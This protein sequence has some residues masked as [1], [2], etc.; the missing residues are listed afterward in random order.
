MVSQTLVINNPT[1]LHTRPG[2]RFVKTAQQ[3]ESDITVT[4]GE[5]SANGKSLLKMLKL[6]ISQGDSVVIECSGADETDALKSLAEFVQTL[7]E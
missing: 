5:A 3:Y 6:G 2:Q 1:G 7:S 4:K